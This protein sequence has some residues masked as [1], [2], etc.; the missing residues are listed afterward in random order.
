MRRLVAA[1]GLLASGVAAVAIL[2]AAGFLGGFPVPKGVDDGATGHPAVALAVDLALVALFGLQHSVMARPAFKQ[3][4]SWLIP[5]T[6][7]RS[8]YVLLA[9]LTLALLCWLWRPLPSTVWELE[10]LARL[11]VQGLFALGWL[12]LLIAAIAIGPLDLLGIERALAHARGR[13]ERPAVFRTPGPYAF[14]RH[15]LMTGF[16]LVFWAAPTMTAGRLLFAVAMTAYILL[17]IRLEERDLRDL[18]GARYRR[19]QEEVPALVPL[20]RG[21]S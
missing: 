11:A 10:G 6:I 12:V 9:G 18:F 8:T 7:E 17:A 21:R 16:L 15:P 13:G 4:S 2:Y 20:P 19:Y 1:Y 14:V 5:A 3:R